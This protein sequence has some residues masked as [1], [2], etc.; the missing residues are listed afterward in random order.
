MR[1]LTISGNHPRHLYYVNKIL[2][3]YPITGCILQK[4]EELVP[5]VPNHSSEN[6]REIFL[7]HFRR[8]QKAEE[9]YF[10]DQTY[11]DCDILEINGE[12]LNSSI[13]MD[14]IKKINPEIVLLFGCGLI[15]KDLQSILPIY[16]VNLHGG[17]SPWYKGVAT[18]FWPFYFLQPNYAGSTFHIISSEVDAG[19]IIHQVKPKLELDDGIHDVGCKT[20]VESTDHMLKLLEIFQKNGKWNLYKQNEVGKTFRNKDFRPEHLRIIYEL[21]DDD[22][23]KHYI[24]GSIIND[25]P[26]IITQF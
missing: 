13:T 26:K 8:R 4:R 18:L 20:I 17:L 1:I 10:G 23:V 5:E 9:K 24:R 19:D 14:F 21:F 16:T 3:K 15:K 25:S 12:Q 7:E 22:I 11:P 2:E 6:D